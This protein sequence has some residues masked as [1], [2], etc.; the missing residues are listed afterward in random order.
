MSP[1]WRVC[2]IFLCYLRRHS[3]SLV[4]DR[5]HACAVASGCTLEIQ[6]SGE[7]LEPILMLLDWRDSAG[8]TARLD[9]A[10]AWRRYQ[11]WKQDRN[12]HHS[13]DHV[14]GSVIR[15]TGF[16][17]VGNQQRTK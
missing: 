8:Q 13:S 12:R 11:D 15:A 9:F 3:Y 6:N 17:H 5:N 16:S 14:K 2:R 1:P 10:S 7:A 4:R